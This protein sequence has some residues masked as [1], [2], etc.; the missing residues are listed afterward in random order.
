MRETKT[1][2]IKDCTYS[3]TQLGA[4]KSLTLLHILSRVTA[5]AFKEVVVDGEDAASQ[6]LGERLGGILERLSEK[7]MR[8]VIDTLAGATKVTL[9]PEQGSVQLNLS[10]L[11]DEH[12]SGARLADMLLWLVESLKFNFSDFLAGLSALLPGADASKEGE[13]SS[14]TD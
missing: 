7:D 12:F 9:A 13:P 2:T 11:F 5:P 1:F 3:I 6:E 14:P 4:Y 10:D 8:T